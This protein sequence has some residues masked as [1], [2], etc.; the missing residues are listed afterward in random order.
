[1]R[2]RGIEDTVKFVKDVRNVYLGSLTGALVRVNNVPMIGR[3]PRCFGSKLILL[4][5]EEGYRRFIVIRLVLTILYSTRSLSIGKVPKFDSISNPPH[6]DYLVDKQLV[7]NFWKHLGYWSKSGNPKVPRKVSFSSYHFTTKSGPNGHALWTAMD[8]LKILPDALF[9]AICL[10]GGVKLA[11][12]MNLLREKVLFLDLFKSKVRPLFLRRMTWF[13]DK[14]DK[15][16]V[17]AVLDFWSQ[18]ALVPMH[19][20]LFKILKFI[21][22]DCTFNQGKL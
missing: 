11:D 13:P 1:M 10:V 17:I 15:M 16:R 2:T 5:E 6:G 12:R 20:F 19:K 18:T 3:Y 4:L 7:Q 8:D 9:A 21:P 22:Q 14:E